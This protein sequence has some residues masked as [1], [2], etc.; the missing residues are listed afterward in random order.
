MSLINQRKDLSPDSVAYQT[1]S[2][3]ID[4]VLASVWLLGTIY[5]LSPNAVDG[6]SV[7]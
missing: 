5:Q 1:K 3:E 4:Q 2:T 7:T 6:R